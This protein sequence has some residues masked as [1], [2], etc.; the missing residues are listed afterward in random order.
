MRILDH[1]ILGP[2]NIEQWRKFHAMHG[3][4]HCRQIV[5]RRRSMQ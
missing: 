5:E 1:P 3:H 4:H 2:L